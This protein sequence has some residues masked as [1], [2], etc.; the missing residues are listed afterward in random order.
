MMVAMMP[1]YHRRAHDPDGPVQVRSRRAHDD[2]G[3]VVAVRMTQGD[4]PG[5]V[6]RAD[7]HGH[8]QA[9]LRHRRRDGKP[10]HGGGEQDDAFH[11]ASLSGR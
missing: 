5:D 6:R 8:A 4:I 3:A 11:G 1:V 10:E 7:G 2:D 9:A